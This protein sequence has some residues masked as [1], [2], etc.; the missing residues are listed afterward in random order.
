MWPNAQ[1]T[2]DLATFTE[3]IL[4]SRKLLASNEIC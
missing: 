1:E 3:E 4:N 2:A